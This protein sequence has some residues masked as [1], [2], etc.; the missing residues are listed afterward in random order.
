MSINASSLPCYSDCEMVTIYRWGLAN[1]AA[2]QTR[3]INGRTI[4]FPSTQDM[5]Q[6]II[7]FEQRIEDEKNAL[8]GTSGGVSVVQFPDPM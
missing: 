3:T 8:A 2:G 7:Y 5:I 4:S 1:A 6:T